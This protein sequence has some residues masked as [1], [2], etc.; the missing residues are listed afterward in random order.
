MTIQEGKLIYHL[1]ALENVPCILKYGLLPRNQIRNFIPNFTDVADPEII[2]F[3]G[4]NDLNDFIPFHFFCKNPFDGRV[5]IKY[6]T[7]R[8][9]YLCVHRE[10]ARQQNYKIITQ[11]PMSFLEALNLYDY[12]EGFELIDWEAMEKRDYA[13]NHSKNVCMA[14]CIAPSVVWGNELFCIYVKTE[15]D[16][17][18]INRQC[19]SVGIQNPCRINIMSGMFYNYNP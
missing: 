18:W 2:T 13:D 14:E 8:F 1:T 10:Y 16:E 11:H 19:L 9:V 3:R 4:E 6:P 12:D 5:Q 15:E 7:S 17:R